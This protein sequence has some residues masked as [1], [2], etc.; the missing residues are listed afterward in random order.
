MAKDAENSMRRIRLQKLTINMSAGESGPKLE[1]SQKL[2]EKLVGK[3]VVVTKTH[4]R[5]TFGLAKGRPIGVKAT[6]RGGEAMELLRRLIKA[7]EGKLKP[8]Q[9]DSSGNFS[10]GI[11]EYINIPGVK[12]DPEVG[13]LGMDVCVT[14][15]RPGCRVKKRMIR[16]A[17]V[18][19][20]HMIAKEDAMRWAEKE[21]GAKV[22]EKEE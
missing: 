22:A 2:M 16:P 21:L 14:L 18:G 10:F 6:L 8:S 7:K 15:E 9:F 12:Y 3:K 13:I 19:K 5:T 17:P 1:K 20:A 11:H 4:D